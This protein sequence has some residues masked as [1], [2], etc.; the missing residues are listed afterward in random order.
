MNYLNTGRQLEL[1]SEIIEWDIKSA[2]ISLCTEFGLIPEKELEYLRSVPKKKCDILIGL[3]SK[4]DKIFAKQLESKFNE[5]VNIF[6]EL[7]NLDKD[8]DILAIKRDAV[9][10]I[11]HPISINQISNNIKFVDKNIYHAY[12]YLKP[13]ELY[14]KRNGEID[15]KHFIGNVD[16]RNRILSL[17]K[18]GMMN[19][20]HS[21]I[22]LCESTN[23]NTVK[24][25]NELSSF[26]KAYKNRELDFDYYRE[27]NIDSKFRYYDSLVSNIN[28]SMMEK[29]DISYNYINFI[30]PLIRLIV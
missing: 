6:I 5:A 7:N 21:F 10:V 16:E 11:N 30:L 20:F 25:S 28:E 23:F 9:F 13:L 17:H 24:I 14:F 2:G 12:L 22:D 1:N 15:I 29:I 4:E 26:V 3:R 19:L 27:F 8:Y 18:D